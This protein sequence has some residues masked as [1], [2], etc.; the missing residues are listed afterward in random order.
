M[1]IGEG[2]GVGSGGVGQAS[3]GFLEEASRALIWMELEWMNRPL[4]SAEMKRVG[5]A[6]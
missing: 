5:G 6:R 2:S 4:E 3:P 1:L